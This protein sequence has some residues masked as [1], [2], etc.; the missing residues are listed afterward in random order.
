MKKIL[1]L[2]AIFAGISQVAQCQISNAEQRKLFNAISAISGL[3]VDSINDSKLVES[4]IEGVLKDLDPHS[5]Y[6]P[7]K[8][9]EKV[10]EPLEGSFEGVGIQF[11][12]FEDS[13]LVVQTVAGC[14]AEKVGVLPGDRII[15]IDNKLI[16]GVKIQNSDVFKMLR[17][18]KGSVVNIRV[19]R[20]KSPELIDFKIVRDK[21][22]LYSVDATYM[23]DKKIG[24]IKINNFG[25]NTVDEFRDALA[26]LEK[27]GMIDLILS[28]QGNGGG[29]LNAAIGL[30][31]EFLP[32]KKVIVYTEGL[33]QPRY[34]AESTGIGGY[35]KG[36][37]IVLVDEYSASAS[38]ILSGAVQD[39]DRGIIVGRRTFGKGLVQRQ[40]PLGDGSMLRL[41]TARY[42]T[43]TGRCIQK[44]YKNGIDQYERDLLERDKHGEFFHADS[45]HFP[46]SLRYQTL[47]LKRTVYGGGGI[48]PDIFVPIDT[49]NYSVYHRKLVAQGVVNKIYVRYLESNREELKKNYPTFDEF[50]NKYQ[51]D[52]NF[53]KMLTDEGEKDKI[54]FDEKQFKK[55]ESLIKL[56]LKALIARDLWDAN[57]YYQIIDQDNESLNKAIEILKSKTG[58]N[59]ILKN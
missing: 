31:D 59:S 24:Y 26:K 51:V 53:I 23:I 16:A 58:Y 45:I 22:P 41:T 35:E 39:W 50:K 49:T 43:P 56:Q 11:Q 20:N 2:L 38:E 40:I 33:N 21:I 28:L 5:V 19:M 12:I 55:S 4:A 44:P 30:A 25:S 13:L 52:D 36:R 42:Y 7:K 54:K 8:E 14:P 34:D 6:I 48:M 9:V 46:D 15:Y 47:R 18:P 37:L 29:Y 57:A 1:L 27:Q 17:G 10:N 3:Y 32:Q